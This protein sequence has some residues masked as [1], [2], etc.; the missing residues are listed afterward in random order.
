MFEDK[1]SFNII[2]YDGA[3]FFTFLYFKSVYLYVQYNILAV[4]N[5]CKNK[6]FVLHNNIF[7]FKYLCRLTGEPVAGLAV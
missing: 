3:V 7:L 4:K 2:I 1:I 6:T 5:I